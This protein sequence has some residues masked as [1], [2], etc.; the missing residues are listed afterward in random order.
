M[1]RFGDILVNLTNIE[2]LLAEVLYLDKSIRLS[3]FFS[4]MILQRA[5]LSVM[6]QD[7]HRQSS[8][9]LLSCLP[10][11]LLQ[12]QKPITNRN[13]KQLDKFGYTIPN[14]SQYIDILKL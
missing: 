12:N 5:F 7:V 11:I 9:L 3:T 2:T 1:I 8:F 10:I 4:L 6:L 13:I 14:I